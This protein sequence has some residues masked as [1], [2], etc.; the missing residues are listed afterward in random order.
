M[1]RYAAYDLNIFSE[2]ELP[3]LLQGGEPYDVII[4]SG[5]LPPLFALEDNRIGADRVWGSTLGRLRFLVEGGT[6]VTVDVE[7]PLGEGVTRSVVQGVLMAALLRQRGLLAIHASGV[8]K[9]GQAIGF[10]GASGRGKSTL[11]EL[12]CQHGYR[13][14]G[15][16]VMAIRLDGGYPVALPGPPLIQLRPEAG[17]WLRRDF[18]ELSRV[19]AGSRKSIRPAQANA[20][21]HPVPIAKLYVLGEFEEGASAI[22]P[23]SSQKAFLALLRHTRAQNLLDAPLYTKANFR[24]CTEVVRHVPLSY[25]RRE[26]GFPALQDLLGAVEQDVRE[27]VAASP[28]HIPTESPPVRT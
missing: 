12:F 20:C 15:D 9:D 6:S 21:L 1:Y 18:K 11:A 25:L 8:V 5:K 2:I 14:L 28:V 13:M 7:H 10:I 24:Q 17:A 3:G 26:R 16:D 4:R 23:L 22:V 19:H 27:T